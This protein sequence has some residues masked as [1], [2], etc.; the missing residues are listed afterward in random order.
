M[1]G[2]LSQH[3]TVLLNGLHGPALYA[4]A[5]LLVF[6]E[7][8]VFLGLVL[9]GETALLL[10]GALAAQ[11]HIQLVPLL[12]VVAVAAVAGDS[13]GYEVGRHLGPALRTGR[14]G[15]RIGQRQWD[16]AE[17]ALRHRGAVAVVLGRWVGVLRALVPG[18]AG[19][20][21]MPYGRFLA[22]NAL[23]GVTWTIVVGTLG[24]ELGAAWRRAEV[25]VGRG[26]VVL[27]CGVLV[28]VFVRQVLR[29]REGGAAGQE[30]HTAPHPSS[31]PRP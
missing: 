4:I 25:W 30:E 18:V 7:A 21:R 15:R 31:S 27:L 29:R 22:A 12:A 2:S 20:A 3:L 1:S 8:A 24:Y 19:A 16:R 23:G 17:H 26:G 6:G 13:V 28:A 14:L 5:G 9:P 10:G 11:G